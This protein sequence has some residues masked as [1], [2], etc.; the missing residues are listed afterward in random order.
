VRLIVAVVQREHI[1]AASAQGF[2]DF[3]LTRGLLGLTT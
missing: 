2:V 1:P 3:Q